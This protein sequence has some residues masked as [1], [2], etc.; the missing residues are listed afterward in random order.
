MPNFPI[1]DTHVHLWNPAKLRY[2]WLEEVPP[3]NRSFLLADYQAA[4]GGIDVEAM[5][6]VQ[7][8][9]HPEDGLKETAWVTSLAKDEPRIK[10]IVAWAPL[11]KSEEAESVLEE[12]ADNS[13]VKGVR[14]LIQSES[15]E[16]CLQPNFI[17]GVQMLEKFGFSFDICISHPQLANTVQFVKSCPDVQFILDHIG[18]PGIKDQRLEPW[19]L[20]IK[21]L[22]ALPNVSCKISGLVTEADVDNW[23]SDDLKPYIDHVV[24]CFG[25]DRVIYGSDWPVSTLATEY[26]RWVETLNW[27]VEGCSDDEL[28]KLFHDNAVRFYRIGG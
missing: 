8:D 12:L 13:L 2:P 10:G 18:K 14:R 26:P 3:L 28:R 22:S 9:A 23:T 15:L 1:V 25:F 4:C 20:D 5:V 6:F 16:F 27:A 11:E 19:K 7:C 24:E 17:K 21:A